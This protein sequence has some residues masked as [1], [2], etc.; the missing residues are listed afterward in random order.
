MDKKKALAR[1]MPF[2]MGFLNSAAL[3]AAAKLEVADQLIAGEKPV[4]EIAL[5]VGARTEMLYRILRFLA[6]QGIF[7]ERPGRRFALNDAGQLM[8]TDVEQA[9]Q[10]FAV[11]NTERGL[12]AATELFEAVKTG[13]IPFVRRF[14]HHPFETL[15][16]DPAAAALIER[17]WQGVH[18]PET[19]A[20][21]EAYDLTGIR[22]L[23]D[24][25]GGHGDVIVGFLKGDA[26][27]RGVIF[28]IPNVAKQVQKRLDAAGLASRCQV[29]AGD[30][31]KEIPVKADAYF[32]RHILHDWNDEECRT[33]LRN[34]AAQCR[35]G[36]RVLIAECVVKEPNVPDTGKLFDMMMML[37]LTGKE[38]TEFEYQDLL[39][40][41]GFEWVGV[42]PTDSIISVVEGR[43]P[44]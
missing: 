30:F 2:Q 10:P 26:Q 18:G 13:E 24:I 21:L 29:V 35:K 5:A 4:E 7:E 41:S 23:A 33:I 42:T 16:K 1:L 31:F 25:G 19:A 3:F 40:S 6:S 17:G 15:H 34:I 20:F 27:R 44:R 12:N 37:F 36:D 28:D 9:Y 43:F 8:R 11:A 39:E 22:T 38:R 14:G 32:M